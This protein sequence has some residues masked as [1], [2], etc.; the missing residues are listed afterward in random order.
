LSLQQRATPAS[1]A[2]VDTLT[3]HARILGALMIRDVQ[4]RFFGSPLGFAI[5]MAFPLSH[6]FILLAINSGLGRAPPYGDSAALFFATGLTPFMCFSYMA[7][8][9]MF[10]LLMNKPLL[11]YPVVKAGDILFA[12]AITEVFNATLVVI[13]TLIILTAIGVEIRPP[14]PLEAMY[15]MFASMWLGLG[16]GLVNGVMAALL[17]PWGTAFGMFQTVMWMASGV[18]FVPDELPETARYWLSF[19]PALIG[20][21]WMRSAYYDGIGLGDLLDKPYMLGFA[22]TSVFLGLLL[23]RAMRGRILR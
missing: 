7:R 17:P 18:I 20:V 2:L 23:E 3:A 13:L 14:R 22:T 21:E 11:G 12:R 6:I 10:G 1:F 16:V 5:A 19:N 4:T 9:T 15:A 8:F